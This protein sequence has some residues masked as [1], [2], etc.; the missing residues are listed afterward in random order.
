MVL[1]ADQLVNKFVEL[2]DRKAAIKKELE[3]KEAELTKMMDAIEDKLKELMHETGAKS[4]RTEHGTAYIT[5]RESA[6]VA[7]WET[8]LAVS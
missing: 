5:Y 8:L 4:M 3:T 1:N 7:D 2:R 6:T